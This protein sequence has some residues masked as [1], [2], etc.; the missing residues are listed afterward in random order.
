MDIPAWSE[1]TGSSNWKDLNVNQK[2]KVLDQWTQDAMAGGKDLLDKE[3]M[4]KIQDFSK[5]Q[6][7]LIQ[8][9][10][11]SNAEGLMRSVEQGTTFGLGKY[12][13]AAIETAL[14]SKKGYKLP[15]MG[16]SFSDNLKDIEQRSSSYEEAHPIASTVANIA[17]NLAVPI[18]A[19]G[20]AATILT[21]AG[22]GGVQAAADNDNL[23][24]A[25]PGAIAG[26][27]IAATVPSMLGLAGKAVGGLKRAI[28]GAKPEAILDR[29][30]SGNT[31]TARELLQEGEQT[32]LADSPKLQGLARSVLKQ[33]PE[34]QEVI[35][36]TLGERAA[37]SLERGVQAT[38]EFSSP[39]FKNLQSTLEGF[40]TKAK[41]AYDQLFENQTP[42][43]SDKINSLIENPEIKSAVKSA[44]DFYRASEKELP[45]LSEGIPLEF[46][47]DVKKQLDTMAQ[48]A[49]KSNNS[50]EGQIYSKFAEQWRNAFDKAVPEYAEAR[51]LAEPYKKVESVMGSTRIVGNE[52]IN[53]PSLAEQ[54]MKP[55][56]TADSIKTELEKLNTLQKTQVKL[57]LADVLQKQF[58]NKKQNFGTSIFSPAEKQKIQAIIGNPKEFNNFIKSIEQEQLFA[59]TTAKVAGGSRTDINLATGDQL[60]VNI[61]SMIANPIKSSMEGMWN[62]LQSRSSGLTPESGKALTNILT[63][64]Q[65]ALAALDKLDKQ[66]SSKMMKLVDEKTIQ[67]LFNQL[68]KTGT[69]QTVQAFDNNH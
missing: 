6:G 61:G 52:V 25:V 24:A 58:E 69:S 9:S 28:L 31:D 17:G 12:G 30:L 47:N 16:Q 50:R 65:T 27:V 64:R 7:S 29:Y 59:K 37:G 23:A 39:Y 40:K 45:N 48:D 3:G 57:D 67:D 19:T 11:I 34:N 36:K 22:I 5:N 44:Q 13:E 46:A 62:I 4:Q 32:L 18:G 15:F 60:P 68:V 1:I 43:I 21:G 2:Q 54:L 42:I 10:D 66:K 35:E 53:E 56:R 14:P 20:R 49:F 41:T 33:A 8:N 63:N 26:G 55:G 38:Q 51:K